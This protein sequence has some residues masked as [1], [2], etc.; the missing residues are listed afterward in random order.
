MTIALNQVKSHNEAVIVAWP[1]CYDFSR[2]SASRLETS[3][4]MGGLTVVRRWDVRDRAVIVLT[5]LTSHRIR[6]NSYSSISLVNG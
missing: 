3:R 1:E 5:S 4:Y 6:G 2:P